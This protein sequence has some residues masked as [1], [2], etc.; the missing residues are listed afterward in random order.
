MAWHGEAEGDWPDWSRLS[1]AH[2]SSPGDRAKGRPIF[3][4]RLFHWQQ[5]GR[6]KPL[7]KTAEAE[8]CDAP[9]QRFMCAGHADRAWARA[10]AF[11]QPVGKTQRL[12]GVGLIDELPHSAIG[13]L[14]ERD[15]RNGR[16]GRD[17]GQA[18]TGGSTRMA[19]K[20]IDSARRGQAS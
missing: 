9:G 17:L 10:D 1:S 19:R 15:G 12:C 5:T 7:V 11:K 3:P 4:D 16:D 14:P 20:V 18:W 2:R 6:H 13:Q 8:C